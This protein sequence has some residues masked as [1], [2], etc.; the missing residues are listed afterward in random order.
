VYGIQRGLKNAGAGAVVLSLWEATD[1]TTTA[2]MTAF[3]RRIAEGRSIAQAFRETRLEDF[4]TSD[5]DSVNNPFYRNVFVLID[6]I[7]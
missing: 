2:F 1:D 4:L 6:A 7:D 5:D 3:H